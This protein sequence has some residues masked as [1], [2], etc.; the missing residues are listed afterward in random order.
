MQYVICLRNPIDVAQSQERYFGCTFEKGLYNSLFFLKCALQYTTGEQRILIRFEDLINDWQSELRRLARF[1]GKS[2][3]GDLERK[4]EDFID[5]NLWHHRTSQKDIADETKRSLS[6]NILPVV[7]EVNEIFI[8]K[9]LVHPNDMDQMLQKALDIIGRHEYD[10][11]M[12]QLHLATQELDA[13]VPAGDS[14]ILVD[15]GDWG[16]EIL[17][18]RR[19]IPFMEKNGNYGGPPPD[20]SAAIKEFERL[21]RFK[22]SFIIFGWPA[23]WWLDYYSELRDYLYSEFNCVF[24]NN[25]VIVF[26]LQR[27]T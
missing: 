5:K 27:N 2:E 11:W 21:R 1:V 14:L 4:V 9:E 23:F 22:P 12:E 3:R 6:D 19:A 10:T 26:D 15:Q 7:L 20:D 18:D 8:Q 17:V 25:R 24:K 13:L 16:Y